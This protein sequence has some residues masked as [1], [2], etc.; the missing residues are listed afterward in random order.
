MR[1]FPTRNNCPALKKTPQIK[2]IQIFHK[3]VLQRGENISIC[4]VL[5]IE[6]FHSFALFLNKL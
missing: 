1:T 3:T 6:G 2:Y 5:T 4:S